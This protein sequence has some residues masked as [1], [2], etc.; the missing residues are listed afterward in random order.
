MVMKNNFENLIIRKEIRLEVLEK[1]LKHIKL[2]K[3][4]K[5]NGT[6]VKYPYFIDLLNLQQIGDTIKLYQ[7]KNQLLK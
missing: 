5:E 4:R 7:Y 6:V 2:L 1:L 3:K